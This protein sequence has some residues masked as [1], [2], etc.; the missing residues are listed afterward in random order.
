LRKPYIFYPTQVRPY[1][2]ISILV[3]A[4]A[5]LRDKKIEIDLVLTGRPSDVPKVE[6]AI[7]HHKLENQVFSLSG[8]AE[9]ELYSLYRYAAA[10]A[11][12]TLLEGGFPWQACEALFMDTPLVVSDIPVVRER[13]EFCGMTPEGSGLTL[14]NPENP[15]ECAL[16]LERV[17]VDRVN[18]LQSQMGFRDK[19]L[20]YSWLDAADRYYKLFFGE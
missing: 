4:M 6:T 20:S 18:A 10:A 11:V 9:N 7:Q 17:L 3:E 13:I 1:K 14:F 19:F 16:A 2:N 5:I 15:Q 12:P 8:V